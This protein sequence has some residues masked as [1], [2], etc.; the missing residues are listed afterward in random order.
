MSDELIHLELRYSS[1]K[2]RYYR[3][4]SER[5]KSY[6]CVAYVANDFDR[7]W[8]PV[9]YQAPYYWPIENEEEDESLAEFIAAFNFLGY[10]CCERGSLENEYQKI[11][12][13][14]D[15]E[16][17]PAHMA[18]QLPNGKWSSKCGDLEDIEHDLEAL[19]G[20]DSKREGYGT[21]ACF[22][23]KK[24]AEIEDFTY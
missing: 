10:E 14:V 23:K 1:L 13:F 12:I 18:K 20:E 3:K 21:I 6:N 7:P 11:A 24:L 15:E 9:P 4:T 19:V 8:W 2:D 5:S 22:M 16:G 17:L